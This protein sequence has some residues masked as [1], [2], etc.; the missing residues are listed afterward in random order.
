MARIYM[1]LGGNMGDR[2][3]FLDTAGKKIAERIGDIACVSSV[4]ETQPWGFLHETSFLNQLVV[5]DTSLQ[6]AD[7]MKAILIIEQQLGRT[8]EGEPYTARTIDIDI[9]FYEDK[10][11]DE[12]DL[13][14]PHPRLHLRRFALEPMA[15]IQGGLVHP[16]FKKTIYMLLADCPD[17]MKVN[18]L[19][20]NPL[21]G[22]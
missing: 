22:N 2:M 14:I 3:N 16:V 10:I 9:L 1:L 19:E 4:Y 17:K 11:I 8:R 12:E 13:V 21:P 20:A 6:P 15:E 18:K 7:A 5:A